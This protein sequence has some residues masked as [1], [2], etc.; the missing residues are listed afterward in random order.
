MLDYYELRFYD[1]L[2]N[3][4][5]S[6]Q[7]IESLQ[8]NRKKNSEGIAVVEMSASIYDL[9]D[10]EKD[11]VL[12]IYKINQ[13]TGKSELQGNTCWFLR[14]AELKVDGECQEHLTLT[15]YDAITLLSRRVVAWAGVATPNYASIMLE[16][17]DDIIHLIAHFN[18]GG[19]VIDPLYPNNPPGV[20]DAEYFPNGPFASYPPIESWQYGVY[21]PDIMSLWNRRMP[22]NLS[23]PPSQSSIAETHR[24][25]FKTCLKA[26]QDIAEVS[27]LKGESLWFDLNYVPATLNTDYQLEFVTWVGV[28][29]SDRTDGYNRMIIGPEFKNMSNVAIVKDWTQEATIV[30]VGGNGD[31]ELKDMASVGVY[32]P[33]YPFYPIETYIS[34]NLGEGIGLHNTKEA[35]NEGYLELS[36][37]T[38]FQTM[39]GEIISKSPTEFGKDFFYG[40]L[41]IAKFKSFEQK[42]EVSEYKI[43][44]SNNNESIEIPFS[45]LG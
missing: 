1:S 11:S 28:R 3:Y 29:G 14:K 27:A 41:L 30:Y 33:E 44:V 2:F 16:P 45:T 34:V 26:M 9:E 13:K 43:T 36:R 4:R 22:I 12:E 23:V 18:F 24:F 35:Q 42:V 17:L 39:T 31:N 32:S 8:Y 7:N 37:R 5:F 40:D 19:G 6:L 25:D 10:F 21:G 20:L 38:K 15:F